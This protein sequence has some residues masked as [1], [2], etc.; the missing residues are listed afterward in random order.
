MLGGWLK[1]LGKKVFSHSD[2][3]Y[4]TM[5]GSLPGSGTGIGASGTRAIPGLIYSKS[6]SKLLGEQRA[7]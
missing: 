2:T 5:A 1:R 3:R 4:F 7:T 6:C